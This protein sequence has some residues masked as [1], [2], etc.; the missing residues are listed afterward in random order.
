M[1]AFAIELTLLLVVWQCLSVWQRDPFTPGRRIFMGLALSCA[2]W[3]LGLLVAREGALPATWSDRIGFL[4]VLTLPALWLG[5]ALCS[6]NP[7]S[8][9][10]PRIA[11]ALLAPQLALYALLW[12][13]DWAALFTTTAAAGQPRPGPLFWANAA[14]SWILVGLGSALF[15]AGAVNAGRRSAALGRVAV[16]FASLVPLATNLVYVSSGMGGPDPTPVPIGLALCVLRATLFSG[17]LLRALPLAQRDLID[18]LPVPVVLTD[19]NDAVLDVNAAAELRLGV[20][21]DLALGRNLYAVLAEVRPAPS[22]SRWPVMSGGREVARMVLVDAGPES[23]AE[24]VEDA[25]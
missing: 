25:A 14:Y 3:C 12:S 19:R 5:L 16:A 10:R 15:L 20:A 17:G 2:C 7:E 4:G 24:P 8:S 9:W 1:Y 13:D 18:E 22:V 11:L 21:L 23:A 6:A